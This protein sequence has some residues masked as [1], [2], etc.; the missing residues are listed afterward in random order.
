MLV[1][2]AVTT[3]TS[4]WRGWAGE[5]GGLSPTCELV[6]EGPT[7]VTGTFGSPLP[8]P[9][10][11][12]GIDVTRS[13]GGTVVSDPAG[14]IDCG[15]ACTAAWP[16]GGEVTLRASAAAGFRF[17]GWEGDCSGTDDA[18]RLTHSEDPD[19]TAVFHRNPIPPGSSDL[20]LR[21]R[22]PPGSGATTGTL[23]VEYGNTF[24]TCELDRCTFSGIPHGTNVTIQPDSGTLRAWEGA[25]TGRAKLCRIVMSGPV[26]VIASFRPGGPRP[27]F[28]INVS[29]SGQGQVR[30]SPN[31]IECPS[32]TCAV[33]F[34]DGTRVQL[35]AIPASP[36]WLF[37]GWR[38][39]CGGTAACTVIAD[40]TR[41]VAAV[42]RLSR[43]PVRVEL[44]GRGRGIVR[45]T[46]AGI[47]CPPDCTYAFP[48]GAAVVLSAAPQAGSLFAGWTGACTG[49]SCTVA[50]G[51]GVVARAAFDRCATLDFR[52]FVAK[53]LR[54][55]R[56][57]R[58][59]LVLTG[60][61][62]VRV[63][64]LRGRATVKQLR[65]GRLAPG[66][67]TLVLTI[68]RRAKPGLH[69]VRVTLVDAC[70]GTKARMRTV[71]LR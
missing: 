34:G 41:F 33:A 57:V 6:V 62:R 7:S 39:D 29:K 19:A 68:P 65:T 51:A 47:E 37:A 44:R 2:R 4:A 1:L 30:S 54:S 50:V 8:L 61:A 49:T 42:F 24:E 64:V 17:L 56:R 71:R 38:G 16:G 35:T 28:G 45:S 23:S 26:E 40:T 55:P 31:G 60:Q 14:V 22:N 11:S 3:G 59:A 10:P 63:V 12:G 46:P 18:C 9:S 27:A 5:C 32:G 20:V 66:T 21:N 48:D 36:R 52:G 58:V 13:E 67:R 43:Q 70:G 53:V 15:T 25:C 69:T